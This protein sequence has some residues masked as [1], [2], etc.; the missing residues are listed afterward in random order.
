MAY[1]NTG[2]AAAA[3]QHSLSMENRERLSLTGVEDVSGFDEGAVVLTTALGELA[4]R[5]ERLHIE[6]IDLELG[7]LEVQ[8]HICEL[9]YAE[10]AERRGIMA[11][12]FS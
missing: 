8:G 1:E 6:R 3:A 11:R 5:G 7:R 12:L 9:S 10:R 4:I 2:A